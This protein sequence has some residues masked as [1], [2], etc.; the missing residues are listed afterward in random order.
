MTGTISQMQMLYS[1]EEDR[2]LFRVN[3]TSRQEFR[4][5]ITR[6]YVQLLERAL[7]EHLES[8]P[9]VLLQASAE[10]RQ[11]VKHYKQAQAAVGANFTEKFKEDEEHKSQLIPVAFKLNYRVQA[12]SLHLGIEP[13]VGQGINMVINR[14]INIS[15]SKLLRAAVAQAAWN[16]EPQANSTDTRLAVTRVVN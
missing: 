2:V 16:L 3:S 13:K 10:D 15:L 12:G 14:E 5:W 1:A 8:D 7:R 11:A 4:F 6:R 9:D